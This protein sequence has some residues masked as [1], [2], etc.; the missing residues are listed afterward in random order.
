MGISKE[1]SSLGNLFRL[2]K[3]FIYYSYKKD[4]AEILADKFLSTM[5][6]DIERSLKII[7]IS[8]DSLIG[9]VLS[10]K[11]DFIKEHHLILVPKML[12]ET[13]EKAIQCLIKGEHFI[14]KVIKSDSNYLLSNGEYDPYQYVQ[15]RMFSKYKIPIRVKE[16]VL[17]STILIRIKAI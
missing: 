6:S 10:Y 15:I 5:G 16:R 7:N 2:A 1:S 12:E 9:K 11:C 3:F 14:P 4:R 8:E 17:R 13:N